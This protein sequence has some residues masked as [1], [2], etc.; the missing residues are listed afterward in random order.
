MICGKIEQRKRKVIFKIIQKN[1][2]EP[3]D[4]EHLRLQVK[5]LNE[6]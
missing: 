5:E 1:L 4:K 6:C 3:K 2:S